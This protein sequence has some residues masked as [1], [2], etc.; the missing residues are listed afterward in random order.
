[1]STLDI[2]FIFLLSVVI[3]YCI[4]LLTLISC[5]T[6]FYIAPSLLPVVVCRLALALV[7][8]IFCT[9]YFNCS[10]LL[11]DSVLCISSVFVRS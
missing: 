2:L 5:I 1:M 10:V 6:H 8:L 3:R 9:H 7:T 11:F 4:G